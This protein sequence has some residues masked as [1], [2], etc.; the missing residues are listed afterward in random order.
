MRDLRYVVFH[1]PGPKWNAGLPIF[2]QEGIH[3]HIAYYRPMLEDGRLVMG[4]PFLDGA[5]GGMMIPE[6]GIGEAEM[7]AFASADPTV[8]SGLLKAEVRPWLVG[9]KK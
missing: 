2:D 9:M 8:Q 6:A 5:A 4:G 1:S 7:V 3:E